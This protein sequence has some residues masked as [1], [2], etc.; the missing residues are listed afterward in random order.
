MKLSSDFWD[1]LSPLRS[2]GCGSSASPALPSTAHTAH[3]ISSSHLDATPAAVLT[4]LSHLQ[5]AGVACSIWAAQSPPASS[6]FPAGTL[7][8]P[9]GT[10]AQPL[11]TLGLL[12][13][14]HQWP[15]LTPCQTSAA[16]HA[17]FMPLN[18]YH[19]RV[20]YTTWFGCQHKVQL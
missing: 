17:R 8:L 6:G 15:P 1:T 3:L 18:Q 16:L 5:N 13:H 12:L 10:Q 11:S 7:T 4:T 9:H 19:L 20:Y 14:L 2:D